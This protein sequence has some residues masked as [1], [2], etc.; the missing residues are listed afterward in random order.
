MKTLETPELPPTFMLTASIS[1]DVNSEVPDYH[2]LCTLYIILLN[3]KR[4]QTAEILEKSGVLLDC[5][6]TASNSAPVFVLLWFRYC[7]TVHD[8]L[9]VSVVTFVQIL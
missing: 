1:A 8:V 7:T 9:A 5:H 2:S 6:E 4:P 3:C